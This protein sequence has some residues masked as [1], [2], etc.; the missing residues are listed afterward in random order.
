MTEHK[1][2]LVFKPYGFISQLGSNDL[3]Q[4]RKKKFL[5]EL[6]DWPEGMMPIGRLDEKSE[7]LLLMTTDGKLSDY[8]NRSG[9][10]KE[11]YALVD[12]IPTQEQLMQLM[13]G[14]AIGLEGEK[15]TTKPCVVKILQESPL[16][17]NRGKKIR[18]ARHGPITWL[19]ITI[20]EGKF[21]Q[22]RKMT[23]AIGCPTLRLVRVRIGNLK[24]HELQPGEVL[25]W[26]GEV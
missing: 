13:Q 6:H 12:G 10:E 9:V 26:D 24:L 7:G 19:S 16:L 14:I 20:Q 15:Y 4:R 22:V 1:H 3:R 18:D 17:P 11:Y 8:I 2:F 25:E 23:S 5:A 21:R